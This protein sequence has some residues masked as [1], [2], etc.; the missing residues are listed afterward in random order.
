[1]GSSR[2]PPNSYNRL[3]E[4]NIGWGQKC[5]MILSE[6]FERFESTCAVREGIQGCGLSH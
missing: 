3:E 1:V 4:K 5:L 6:K 2:Q